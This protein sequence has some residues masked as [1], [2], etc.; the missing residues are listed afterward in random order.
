ML[1]IAVHGTPAPQG[2]KSVGRYGQMYESSRLLKPW[3]DAVTSAATI[4]IRRTPG[5]QTFTGPVR[6]RAKFFFARPKSHYRT[7]RFSH[8]LKPWAPLFV[9][10][11]PDIEKLLRS[12]H[13]ALTAAGVWRDDAL[14]VAVDS[15]MCYAR[16]AGAYIRITDLTPAVTA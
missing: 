2:S 16:T 13:D 8:E 4:A 3:R 11:K 14:V 12:T 7:G 5:F 1:E 9:F 10:T 15:E 6:V